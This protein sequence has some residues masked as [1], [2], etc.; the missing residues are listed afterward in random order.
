[1]ALLIRKYK[2]KNNKTTMLFCYVTSWLQILLC[3]SSISEKYI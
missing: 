3:A 2:D 1:M